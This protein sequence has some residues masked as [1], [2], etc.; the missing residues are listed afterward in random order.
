[1]SV[2]SAFLC[3]VSVLL[4]IA[5]GFGFAQDVKRVERAGFW[6]C[7]MAFLVMGIGLALVPAP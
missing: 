7:V 6:F 5:G 4:G 2:L 3:F 1:M